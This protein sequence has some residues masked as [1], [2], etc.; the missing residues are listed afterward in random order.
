MKLDK[1]MKNWGFFISCFGG[2]NVEYFINID[3]L[4]SVRSL[5]SY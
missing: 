3:Y 1:V 4:D 2:V 5:C